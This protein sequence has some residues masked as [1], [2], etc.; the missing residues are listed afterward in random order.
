MTV[1]QVERIDAEALGYPLDASQREVA[2]APLDPTHVG[3][4][5]L[6]VV[7]EGFLTHSAGL[8]V[9]PEVAAEDGLKLAFHAVNGFALILKRLQTDE[10]PFVSR[11]IRVQERT[12][13]SSRK[14]NIDRR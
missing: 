6:K 10:Y 3:A 9:C 5:E 2:L 7:G 4:V 12:A 1:E 14:R 13:G 8:P 11:S